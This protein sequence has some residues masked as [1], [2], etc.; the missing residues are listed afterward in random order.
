MLRNFLARPQI[1][2]TPQFRKSHEAAARA[3]LMRSLARLA[4]H[5]QAQLPEWRAARLT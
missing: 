2:A 1:Y 3:N 5:Q 4:A